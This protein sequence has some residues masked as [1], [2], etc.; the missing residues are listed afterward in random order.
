MTAV[1]EALEAPPTAPP[2]RLAHWRERFREVSA[3]QPRLRRPKAYVNWL[4]ANYELLTRSSAIGA[5]PLKL[6]FDPTNY[7]Q[8]RC[9]LC[10]T[11]ARIQ[12]RDRGRAQRHVFEHLME[13]VGDYVFLIDFFNWGEPLLN[14]QAE[15]LVSIASRRNI[16][17]FMSS[18]LSIPMND[19]RIGRLVDSGLNQLIVSLDGASAETYGTYRRIGRFDLVI[20]NMK[21]VLAARRQR[22]VTTPRVNWQFLVFRF[23][24][25]EIETVRRMAADMGV[26]SV[27]FRAPFLDEGRVPL[28]DRDKEAVAGWA[29][30]RLEFNRYDEASPAHTVVPERP[31]C[32]WHYMSTA[33]N[34]DGTVAPCCTVF[35]RRDD[36]GQ[37]SGNGNDYMSIVN[38]AKFRGVRDNFA[39]RPSDAE[40]LVCLK[41]PTPFLMDYHSH[42]NRQILMYSAASAIDVLRHPVRRLRQRMQERRVLSGGQ[43][44]VD[45]DVDGDGQNADTGRT[46]LFDSAQ[47]TA[48][49][50]RA[51]Q[52]PAVASDR[53]VIPLEVRS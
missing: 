18:N 52:P 6:T 42:V 53:R 49:N 21:R 23:N 29:P 17:T 13:E 36:F 41:C 22:G 20:S 32:G 35:E 5:R 25:H 33:I 30:T 8:L 19:Q 7:C 51:A 44:P 9:P 26:D 2:G 27:T 47:N 38:N 50:N 24:E 16:V 40:G 45:V 37:L 34:W 31:R 11:G 14:E 28:S 39:G 48:N 1:A 3:L 4:R 46:G 12:D 15:E 10:P 43:P